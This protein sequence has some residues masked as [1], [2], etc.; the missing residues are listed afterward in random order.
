MPKFEAIRTNL[1]LLFRPE[2]GD[3]TLLPT[4]LQSVGALLDDLS[5]NMGAVMQ[6]HWSGFADDA[7]F[8]AYL[9]LLRPLEGQAPLNT[10]VETDRLVWER[11]P[12]LRDLARIGA[13]LALPPYRDPVALREAVEAYRRRLKRHVRHR[14]AI[15]RQGQQGADAGQIPQVGKPLPDQAVGLD[16]G[17]QWGLALQLTHQTK[18]G[19]EFG[20]VGKPAPM[21]LHDRSQVATEIIQQGARRL[22]KGGQ[23]SGVARLRTK[24]QGQV[25]ADGFKFRHR[26]PRL[27]WSRRQAASAQK[28]PGRMPPLP[29]R[30]SGS[31]RFVG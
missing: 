14:I 29:V 25:G 2:P 7:K 4:F 18:I 1:P 30:R 19:V 12:Y 9:G 6:A 31:R 28:V 20:I 8:D 26:R 11:F 5:S 13:L 3:T 23:K 17:I 21:G 24:Q 15:G 10:S 22:H 16:A 27:R